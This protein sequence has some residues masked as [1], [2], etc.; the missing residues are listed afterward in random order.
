M[1]RP[2]PLVSM[3][4]ALVALCGTLVLLADLFFGVLTDRDGQTR[5]LRKQMAESL[6]VQVAALLQCCHALKLP[7]VSGRVP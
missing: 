6:A 7:V 3:T 2:G 5:D 1:R 4:L